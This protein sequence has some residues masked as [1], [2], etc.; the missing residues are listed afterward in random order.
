MKNGGCVVPMAEFQQH[1][2]TTIR[3]L[4]RYRRGNAIEIRGGYVYLTA[5]QRERAADWLWP[6]LVEA[7]RP[8][9]GPEFR[10]PWKKIEAYRA[11]KGP[12]PNLNKIFPIPATTDVWSIGYGARPPRPENAA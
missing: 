3:M 6:H 7:A 4:N 9:I 11:G 2:R 10:V 8:L 1:M 12:K 5:R